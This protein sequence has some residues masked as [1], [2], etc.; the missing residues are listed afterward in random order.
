M[1]KIRTPIF[2]NS[3]TSLTLLYI[4]TKTALEENYLKKMKHAS[5]R[6]RK[7][8]SSLRYKRIGRDNSN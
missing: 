5:S 8:K 7:K 2:T 6:I 3:A 4:W 1:I